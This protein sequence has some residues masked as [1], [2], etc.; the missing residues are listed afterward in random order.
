M[1]L[2]TTRLSICKDCAIESL[3]DAH[4]NW[5]HSLFINEALGCVRIED[6]IVIE[7]LGAEGTC[8]VSSIDFNSIL[9]LE[10]DELLHVSTDK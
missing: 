9:T 7:L 6:L 2:A 4:D 5:L 1:R 10:V 3:H 8:A